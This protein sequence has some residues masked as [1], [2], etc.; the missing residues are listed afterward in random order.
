[1]PLPVSAH[2]SSGTVRGTSTAS[3]IAQLVQNHDI[4]EYN[5]D[6]ATSFR[7]QVLQETGKN[8]PIRPLPCA[9]RQRRGSGFIP[10][11]PCHA[12]ADP[13]HPVIIDHQIYRPREHPRLPWHLRRDAD[14]ASLARRDRDGQTARYRTRSV[15]RPANQADRMIATIDDI[16]FRLSP[17]AGIAVPT[18]TKRG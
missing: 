3:A 2:A 18:S 1:M 4:R 8:Q 14:R 9:G 7:K 5:R 13:L 12:K 6:M 16:D 10:D 17:L 15:L 11:S